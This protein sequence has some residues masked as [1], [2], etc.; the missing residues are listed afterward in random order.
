MVTALAQALLSQCKLPEDEEVNRV[1]RDERLRIV[2]FLKAIP[3]T[4]IGILGVEKAVVT[5]GGVQLEEIDF[6]TMRSRMHDNL[7]L[8]GDVLD[9]DRPSG[10]YSLQ[11]CFTTGWVAGTHS[12][13]Q[14]EQ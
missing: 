5:S 12:A 2:K 8:I 1:T 14:R 13:K 3:L 11:L 7:Y 10:G 6:K 9:V 4:P